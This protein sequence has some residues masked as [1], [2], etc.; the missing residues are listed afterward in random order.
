MMKDECILVNYMDEVIGHN[1]KYNCHKFAPGQPRGLLHRAFSVLLFDSENRLLL[2]QRARSKITFPLV[3]TN[4]CCSHPLYGMK[5]CEVDAPEA[6]ASG[7]PKG[8]KA[9][10]VRKLG[11]ELGIPA[12]SLEISRF[13]FLTRVHYWAVDVRTH[14]D[15]AIWGEH[16]IDHI[17]LYRLNPGETLT[18]KPNPEEVEGTR[19]LAKDELKEAMKGTGDMPLWSPWFKIITERLLDAWWQ[20]LDNALSTDKYVDVSSI[21]RFDTAP[22]FHGGLGKAGPWLDKVAEAEA[23]A[24]RE[25]GEAQRRKAMLEAE[26]EDRVV[27]FVGRGRAEIGS[28]AGDVKQGGYGKVPTHK[29]PKLDQLMRPLE[30]VSALRLKCTGLLENN[31]KEQKDPDVEFCDDML[32]KVSRSFAAVIRQLPTQLSID[33]CVFYL[34]LRALDTVEDDMEA[35]KGRESEKQEELIHFGEKRLS[36]VNCSI[37][38]V[39]AADERTLIENFGRVAKVF[40]KLPAGSKDVIKDITDKMGAGMAEYVSAN[41]AQGTVDQAAYDRYC[42][43][44]AGLVGEGLTRIFVASGL[45]GADL[46]GQGERSWPF[47]ADPKE[48]PSNLGLANSMGLFLQ[49]TNIIRDYLEDYVDGRAFW[50]QTVWKSYACSNDLGEFALPTAHAAGARLAVKAGGENLAKGV[51]DQALLCLNDLVADALELVPDSLEYLERVKTP[52]IYRFCAIPQV[53]AIATL[54]ECFDNPRVFTGVVK[55]RKGL[56][57]RLIVACCDG[58][59]AVHFWFRS[60]AEDILSSVSQGKCAGADGPIGRRLEKGCARIL[61]RTQKRSEAW[62]S[63][64]TQKRFVAGAVTALAVSSLFLR[65]A[66]HS[67][68]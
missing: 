4:T 8:V 49:K 6:V 13:K 60:F 65:N 44:V 23:T 47:C 55:I 67:S 31:I 41:L 9:A 53:M 64:Q 20:D 2:Q 58:P 1:N 19:W 11:H 35:Y 56:T 42:H 52:S 59:D 68:R 66:D 21:H 28:S 37:K 45:E 54:A 15:E 17:L 51:G 14:G 12:A 34:A 32:G 43:M 61:E 10:A 3:W 18:L 26:H 29:N 63:K 38:G 36:D 33:I 7:D 48:E 22:E 57:A 5:P 39:G 50:P 16:E 25:G 62:S 30:I 40:L 24:M 46:A 27:G